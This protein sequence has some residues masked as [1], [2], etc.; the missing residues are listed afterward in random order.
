[1]TS[2][3]RQDISMFEIEESSKS[4]GHTLSAARF[5]IQIIRLLLTAKKESKLSH[6]EIAARLQITE[7]RVSQVLNGDGN[8]HIAT[9]ARFMH[10][11]GYDLTLHATPFVEGV[12]QIEVTSRRERRR[13]EQEHH[14]RAELDVYQQ[15]F[16]TNVGV[17]QVPMFIP[18]DD[19]LTRLPY[20][21]PAYAGRIRVG[22]M[23][24]SSTSRSARPATQRWRATARTVDELPA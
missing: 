8:V 15:T 24:R 21:V 10:V 13:R 1:M 12:R 9:L 23:K 7:G 5:A 2:E 3:D 4:G 22:A 19:D 18:A 14:Q 20:G 17:M 16:L 6:R 11:M